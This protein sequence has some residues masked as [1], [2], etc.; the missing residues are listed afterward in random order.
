MREVTSGSMSGSES[1]G[2]TGGSLV[3]SLGCLDDSGVLSVDCQVELP[4]PSCPPVPEELGWACLEAHLAD[5]VS[6]SSH[7]RY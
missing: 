2:A 7:V 5:S 1:S 3:W 6:S 4:S